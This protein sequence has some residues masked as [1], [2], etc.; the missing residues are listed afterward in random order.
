MINDRRWMFNYRGCRPCRHWFVLASCFGFDNLCL[1]VLVRCLTEGVLPWSTEHRSTIES[2]KIDENW[3]CFINFKQRPSTIH[4]RLGNA[5]GLT[6]SLS[7]MQKSTCSHSPPDRLNSLS[8]LKHVFLIGFWLLALPV[9]FQKHLLDDSY[10]TQKRSTIECSSCHMQKT[11]SSHSLPDSL[12][13]LS[14]TKSW[15]F[16]WF[17]IAWLSCCI[18]KTLCIA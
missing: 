1:C 4:T 5:L 12:N 18:L 15:I 13:L 11:T 3:L 10:S 14:H 2:W 16:D 8:H 17:L 9:S 7:H 6:C